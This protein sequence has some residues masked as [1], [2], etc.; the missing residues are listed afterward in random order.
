MRKI[1]MWFT[2]ATLLLGGA[3][4]VMFLIDE[5]NS[6]APSSGRG[7]WSLDAQYAAATPPTPTAPAQPSASARSAAP[8]SERLP[9]VAGATTY[10]T[11]DE[12]R[13]EWIVPPT[14]DSDGRL[15]LKVRVMD[16]SLTLHPDGASDGNGLDVNITGP[17][18]ASR[19]PVMYGEI[20]PPAGEGYNWGDLDETAFV[21]DLYD[22]D[23]ETRTLTMEVLTNPRL[24]SAREIYASLW[25][26]PPRGEDPTWVNRARI[27]TRF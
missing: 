25:T 20:L 19:P 2:L 13:V 18:R 17:R 3:L 26:N 16:D 4:Y 6:D 12:T 1:R 21:A 10:L 15:R 23:F 24:A 5:E 22:F 11:G 9:T 14:M 8:T 27:Q 7:G